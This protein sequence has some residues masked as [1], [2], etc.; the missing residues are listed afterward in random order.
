LTEWRNRGVLLDRADMVDHGRAIEATWWTPQ[1]ERLFGVDPSRRNEVSRRAIDFAVLP[2]GVLWSRAPIAIVSWSLIWFIAILIFGAPWRWRHRR[3]V[4]RGRCGECGHSLDPAAPKGETRLERCSECGHSAQDRRPWITRGMLVT[5]VA[6]ALL[7]VV[8]DTAWAWLFTSRYEHAPNIHRAAAR[9]DIDTI[10]RELRHG[11]PVDLRCTSIH[12]QGTTPL[13]WAAA[14]GRVRAVELLVASGANV[15]AGGVS[16]RSWHVLSW[17]VMGNSTAVLDALGPE[18]DPSRHSGMSGSV[19]NESLRLTIAPDRTEVFDWLLS[20]FGDVAIDTMVEPDDDGAPFLLR[21]AAGSEQ[22]RCLQR[23]LAIW[24]N[25]QGSRDELQ[26]HLRGP[27]LDL[28]M[29]AAGAGSLDNLRFLLRRRA[30]LDGLGTLLVT[31]AESGQRAAV[32]ELLEAGVRAD[33]ALCGAIVEL[34]RFEMS[35]LLPAMIAAGADPNCLDKADGRFPLGVAV[36][37]NDLDAI[38]TLNS[39][40]A[41]LTHAGHDRWPLILAIIQWDSTGTFNPA[42]RDEIV[43]RLFDLAGSVDRRGA[44][45]RTAL[46]IA[47]SEGSVRWVRSLLERGADPRAIDQLGWSVL[48]YAQVVRELG[49]PSNTASSEQFENCEYNTRR[50]VPSTERRAVIE[51]I[52]RALERD[53]Q[54]GSVP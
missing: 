43:D 33:P 13:M 54:G 44:C 18:V 40:G 11:I 3:R 38:E 10:E 53:A 41:S 6:F 27:W 15:N 5:A 24:E 52:D 45:A 29:A 30:S 48:D 50:E 28:L 1:K 34:I 14:S 20:R 32:V 8:A 21:W 17:A 4:R 7:V 25:R 22:S 36:V 9:D 46:M 31:A 16:P 39:A 2:T 35:D 49:L 26:Q 19:V 47:A 23:L 51:L 37:M 42:T 12:G